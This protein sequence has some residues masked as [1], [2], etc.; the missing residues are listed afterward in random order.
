MIRMGLTF[1]AGVGTVAS[2]IAGVVWLLPGLGGGPEMIRMVVASA[3]W[4][5]PIGVVFSGALALTAH[6]RSFDKLSLPR[7]AALGAGVGLAFFGL[8]ATNAWQAWSLSTAIANATI[9]VVLGGGSATAALMLARRAAPAL[10]P[11]DES[12]SVGEGG[13]TGGEGSATELQPC[14]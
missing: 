1:S 14:G 7:F 5:F 3:I 9:F 13:A 12:L 10:A 8:L 6:G 2:A 11:G 4:A